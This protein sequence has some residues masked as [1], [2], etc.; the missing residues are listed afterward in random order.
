MSP[1]SDRNLGTLAKPTPSSDSARPTPS[2]RK[3]SLRN[4]N[5]RANYLLTLCVSGKAF[6]DDRMEERGRVTEGWPDKPDYDLL[7]ILQTL[8]MGSGIALTWALT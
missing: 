1:A 5:H 7:H 6:A 2:Q 3:P 4:G 8:Y